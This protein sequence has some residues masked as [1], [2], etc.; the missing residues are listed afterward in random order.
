M[1]KED[2]WQE[3]IR[4]MCRQKQWQ[5]CL[6]LLAFHKPRQG[7]TAAYVRLAA[8]I[9]M[10]MLQQAVPPWELI[11]LRGMA[12]IYYQEYLGYG[13]PGKNRQGMITTSK[14]ACCEQVETYFTAILQRDRRSDDMYAYAQFLYKESG[15]FHGQ[16]S[17]SQR[18]AQQ[19][20]AYAL[21][22]ESAMQ[23]ESA[24]T[25]KDTQLYFQICYGLCRCGLTFFSLRSILSEELL[26]LFSAA[27]PLYGKRE[28]HLQRLR[29]IYTCMDKVL[30]LAELPR[31]TDA[32][33]TVAQSKQPYGQSWNIYYLLGKLFDC[34][35]QFSLCRDKSMSR[36]MAEQYYTY[37]CEIDFMRRRACLPVSGFS[38][39]YTALLTLYIRNRE[40]AKFYAAWDRYH[41]QIQ[42]SDAFRTVCQVRWLII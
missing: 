6:D 42:F 32:I 3:E 18:L 23:I 33:Q 1:K 26:L 11:A 30:S 28:E 35:V 10:Q 29:R 2:H 39:M 31:K 7:Q 16:A 25:E 40:E 17:F 19:K 8:S 14:T 24:D 13:K 37:A 36:A 22:E 38:H 21:Y 9:Y 15:S 41:P 34:A 4:K 12:A 20:Q 5:R 27:V